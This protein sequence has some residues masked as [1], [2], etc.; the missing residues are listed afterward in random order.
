ME[1]TIV[2]NYPNK[3]EVK[4]TQKVCFSQPTPPKEKGLERKGKFTG[5]HCW[6]IMKLEKMK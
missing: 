3:K 1:P 2:F 4:I 6:G 5:L